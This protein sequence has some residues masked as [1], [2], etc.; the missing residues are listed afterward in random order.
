MDD[1]GSP[2]TR[3]YSA[4]NTYENTFPEDFVLEVQEKVSSKEEGLECLYIVPL[5]EV[6]HFQR[7]MRTYVKKL[8]E[9]KEIPAL[10]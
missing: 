6:D 4:R 9:L 3:D 10:P 7:H 8:G 1:K 2:F 5:E